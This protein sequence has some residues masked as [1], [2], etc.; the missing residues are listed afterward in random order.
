MPR[1]VSLTERYCD[2]DSRTINRYSDG[3]I[4]VTMSWAGESWIRYVAVSR[5]HLLAKVRTMRKSG[6]QYNEIKVA[7]LLP[8]MFWP[9][10]YGGPGQAFQRKPYRF[11]SN[12]RYIVYCQTGGLDI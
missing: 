5:K 6:Y 7:E 3:T 10:R 2:R 4:V 11:R 1:L 9:V 8:D 12:R